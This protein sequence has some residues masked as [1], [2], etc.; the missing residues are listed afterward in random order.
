MTRAPPWPSSSREGRTHWVGEVRASPPPILSL[1]GSARWLG[2]CFRRHCCP[3]DFPVTARLPDGPRQLSSENLLSLP[4]SLEVECLRDTS[5][6]LGCPPTSGFFGC[7]VLFGLL[8][9]AAFLVPLCRA[10][11]GVVFLA[12]LRVLF[13]AI[14][15][16]SSP[17]GR[18]LRL[19][20]SGVYVQLACP[21]GQV[22]APS[23]TVL[24]WRAPDDHPNPG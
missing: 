1:C 11:L 16:R 15:G 13:H 23:A 7:W 22:A 6:A 20:T 2:L 14:P 19:P 5:V 18:I 17:L 21:L 10:C 24:Q 9:F 8:D 12:V 3:V 4:C